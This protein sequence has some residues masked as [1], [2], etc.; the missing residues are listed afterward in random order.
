[1]PF[2]TKDLPRRNRDLAPIPISK[3]FQP[4]CPLSDHKRVQIKFDGGSVGC[5]SGHGHLARPGADFNRQVMS[6]LSRESIASR[7]QGDPPLVGTKH[8]ASCVLHHGS[9]VDTCGRSSSGLTDSLDRPAANDRT[10]SIKS[11]Q[12]STSDRFAIKICIIYKFRQP[13]K[14][15]PRWT[16]AERPPDRLRADVAAHTLRATP[17]PSPSSPIRAGSR[18]QR[19][20]ADR[21]PGGSGRP[22]VARCRDG[23]WRAHHRHFQAHLCL[24]R[25]PRFHER[26]GHGPSTGSRQPRST[27]PKDRSAPAAPRSLDAPRPLLNRWPER[28][29]GSRCCPIRPP[30]ADVGRRADPSSAQ[31]HVQ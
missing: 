30:A 1:M 2:D 6:C 23:R 27:L 8:V 9:T 24:A 11:S 31:K 10:N 26:A 5:P 22:R 28:D 13:G 19:R 7:Q 14:L 25:N 18:P 4:A 15:A 12:N 29:L 17:C 20:P 16:R 21:I 3:R